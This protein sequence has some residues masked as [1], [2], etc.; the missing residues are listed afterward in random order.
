M[1]TALAII[2]FAAA[3]AACGAGSPAGPSPYATFGSPSFVGDWKGTGVITSIDQTRPACR[4]SSWVLGHE[5]PIEISVRQETDQSSTLHLV[6][7]VSG[8][9]CGLVGTGSGSLFVS[10]DN[11]PG[12]NWA[13]CSKPLDTVLW[14]CLDPTPQVR[15]SEVRMSLR[16]DDYN[17]KDHMQGV[18]S[19]SIAYLFPPDPELEWIVGNGFLLPMQKTVTFARQR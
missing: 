4:P 8:T 18:F 11:N 1:R 7:P 13:V 3:S 16:F 19:L 12:A 5:E 2:V 15:V 6:E 10:E 9:E 17:D 14:P